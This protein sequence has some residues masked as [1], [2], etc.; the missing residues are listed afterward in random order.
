MAVGLVPDESVIFYDFFLARFNADGSLDSAF[1]ADGTTTADFGENAAASA[2][3][4][5]PDGKILVAGAIKPTASYSED[6]AVVRFKADGSVDT[7]FGQNGAAITDFNSN[8][9]YSMAN[10]V[11]VQ[12]DGKIVA[13]GRAMP[14]GGVTD[15]FVLA[16]YN[17]DGSL[18]TGFGN[19]GRVNTDF[20][21]QEQSVQTLALMPDGKILAAGKTYTANNSTDFALAR[22]NPDGSPDTTFGA[23]GRATTDFGG[24][25]EVIVDLVVPGFRGYN[26]YRRR[27]QPQRRSR[28]FFSGP[29]QGKRLP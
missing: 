24:G 16:R 19:G 10:A 27:P 17:P 3:V 11:L 6:F 22:Y 21:G 20:D 5:Q 25:T 12:P 28:R 9:A 15:D 23:G 29:L 7:D 18:D 13:G 8:A 26:S 2:A 4:I 14:E 1:G